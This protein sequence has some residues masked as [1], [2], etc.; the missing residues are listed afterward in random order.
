MLISR[1]FRLPRSKESNL[2]HTSCDLSLIAGS[3]ARILIS[4]PVRKQTQLRYLCAA[5]EERARYSYLSGLGVVVWVFSTRLRKGDCESH[6]FR[7][8]CLVYG[9]VSD[10]IGCWHYMV[11]SVYISDSLVYHSYFNTVH[12]QHNMIRLLHI[13]WSSPVTFPS[14]SPQESIF[15]LKAGFSPFRARYLRLLVPMK[16]VLFNLQRICT[17][18]ICHADR[19]PKTLRQSR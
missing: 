17:L 1:A 7:D 12:F 8:C 9:G 5:R 3:G 18:G 14:N 19:G 11:I 16:L 13:P 15:W 10:I 6:R 2:L 4:F